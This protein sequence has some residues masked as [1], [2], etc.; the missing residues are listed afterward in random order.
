[1]MTPRRVHSRLGSLRPRASNPDG[2]GSY[3]RRRSLPSQAAAPRRRLLTTVLAKVI[4]VLAAFGVLSAIGSYYIPGILDRASVLAGRQ[5][6]EVN[7]AFPPDYQSESFFSPMWL[8]PLTAGSQ[9][10]DAPTDGGQLHVWQAARGVM[11]QDQS[12]RITVSGTDD[13]PVILQ[14]ISPVIVSRTEPLSGWFTS[15]RGCGGVDVREAHI[16]LDPNPPSIMFS[17]QSGKGTPQLALTLQVSRTDVEVIDVVATTHEATVDWVL[18]IAYTVDGRAGTMR[19]DD[20]GRPFRVS[21]LTQGRATGYQQGQRRLERA[22][23]LDPVN[24][25]TG[26]C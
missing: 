9:P 6:L 13:R 21:A 2:R 8:V 25:A 26:M 15:D 14:S 5:P 20:H 23:W 7:V 3:R 4:A 1:L 16:Q 10:Q 19:I 12:L 17:D 22:T 24:G 18:Q 11:G